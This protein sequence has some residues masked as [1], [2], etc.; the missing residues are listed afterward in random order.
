[1][2]TKNE[3]YLKFCIRLASAIAVLVFFALWV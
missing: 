2:E 3:K 1:M